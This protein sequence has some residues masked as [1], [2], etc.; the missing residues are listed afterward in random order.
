M[1]RIPAWLH[2]GVLT[3]VG[4]FTPAEKIVPLYFFEDDTLDTM[5]KRVKLI[6]ELSG[7]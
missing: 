3:N 1:K 5:T 6:Y 4:P 7:L 2:N